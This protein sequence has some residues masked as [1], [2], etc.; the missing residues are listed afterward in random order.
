MLMF[1]AMYNTQ[2]MMWLSLD[3]PRSDSLSR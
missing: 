3:L 2:F 1:Y